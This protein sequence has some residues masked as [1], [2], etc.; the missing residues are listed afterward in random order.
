MKARRWSA[1]ISSAALLS[2]VVQAQQ[3]PVTDEPTSTISR[4]AAPDTSS[5]KS[6]TPESFASAAASIS[7]AEIELG[8]LAMERTQDAKVR[9]YAQLMVRD[10]KAQADALKKLASQQKIQLP[11]AL[12]PKH[13]GIKQKLIRLNGADF[14]REYA[15][16][17]VQGHDDAVA[18]FE[19]ASQAPQLTSELKEFAANNLTKLKQHRGLAHSLEAKAGA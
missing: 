9:Q 10:H 1:F 4:D 13:Q 5:S 11:Q 3:P 15:R 19:S 7:R 14:D 17:M 8:Q 2:L 12:D 18:L 16:T 6:V